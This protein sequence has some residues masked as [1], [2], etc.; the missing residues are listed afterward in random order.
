MLRSDTTAL[1]ERLR[2]A[3]ILLQEV[4]SGA[5]ENMNSIEHTMVTRVSEFVSTMNELTERSG[6]ASSEV[7]GH[8]GDFHNVTTRVLGDLSQ[9]AGQFENHGRSLA[10]AVTL[11]EHSNRRTQDTIADRRATLEEL[12]A[13][14][15]GKT[16]DLGDRLS[17]FSSLLDEFLDAAANRARDI[18][19]V[20]ADFS[21]EG[22]RAVDASLE[23]AASRAGEI[24]SLLA[25]FE[26]RKRAGDHRQFR[27]HSRLLR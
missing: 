5:H 7:A 17:R 27:S 1:F 12:I 25:E 9:L 8:I 11:L 4:L 23:T 20:I 26:Q 18:A 2:E 22:Q 15:D 24:A 3:N 13:D 16:G 14:L 19:R 21:V 6:S 10:D